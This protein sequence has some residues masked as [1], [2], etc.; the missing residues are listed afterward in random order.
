M[1]S[2]KTTEFI[3]L[4]R[5]LPVTPKDVEALRRARVPAPVT[6][7]ESVAFLASLP[8]PTYEQLK[9]RKGPSGAPFRL[10]F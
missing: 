9:N 7:L 6:I 3:D 8:Q 1:S 4:E 2:S 5:G 10:E